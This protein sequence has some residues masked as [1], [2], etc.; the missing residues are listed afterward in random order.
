MLFLLS[1][2]YP[3][4]TIYP[5]T[6]GVFDRGH[7]I[8]WIRFRGL[9]VS[10]GSVLPFEVPSAFDVTFGVSFLFFVR[11]SR[12]GGFRYWWGSVRIAF[13]RLSLIVEHSFKNFVGYCLDI[14][15]WVRNSYYS[16]GARDPFAMLM[17]ERFVR[18]VLKIACFLFRFCYVWISNL[19]SDRALHFLCHL[20]V[21]YFWNFSFAVRSRAAFYV[22]FDGY[23]NSSILVTAVT[24]FDEYCKA[25]L[26]I[27][28][29]AFPAVSFVLIELH[30][31][32]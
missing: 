18:W 6:F 16:F 14:S 24:V 5:S 19:L 17:Y 15:N 32:A 4:L 23:C 9:D 25:F 2:R 31:E 11:C 30:S 28:E 27:G 21:T 12:T 10:F 1:Q 22:Q 3:I 26:S 8:D 29:P 7:R 20:I 13:V